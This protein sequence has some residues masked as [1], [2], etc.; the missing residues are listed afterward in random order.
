MGPRASLAL[1]W[2][3]PLWL[4]AGCVAGDD[5]TATPASD[6]GTA[7]GADMGAG[8]TLVDVMATDA[9]GAMTTAA[10]ARLTASIDAIGASGP[11]W[12]L[13]HTGD[14]MPTPV[15]VINPMGYA[16]QADVT[17]A[18]TWT[19]SV[20]F[21]AG[22][23]TTPRS[24]TLD[25]P[26]G[27]TVSYRFRVLPPETSGF[28]LYETTV[29][30]TGGMSGVTQ[31][32][33]LLPGTPVSGTLRLAG[34]PTAGE[35]RLIAGDG[36]D[37]VGL[38]DKNGLFKLAVKSDIVYTPLLIPLP[39]PGST[40]PPAGAPHLGAAQTGIKFVGAPFDIPGGVAVSGSVVDGAAAPIAQAHVVLRAGALPSSTGI[41]D[42]TGAWSLYAEAATYALSFDAPDW[43]Q[44][45][46]ANVVVPAAGTSLAIAY[47]T[48]RTAVGGSVTNDDGTAAAMA[49]VT[50]TSQP[51][52]NVATVSVGGG[53]AQPAAGRV[54]RIVMTRADGTLPPLQLPQGTYHVTVEPAGPSL[55]GLTAFNETVGS[56][57]ATWTLPLAKLAPL[58][59]RVVGLDGK[60]VAGVALTAI[61]TLGLGAAP[62]G[63]TDAMG[64]A[65]LFVGKGSPVQLVV[66]PPGST[67]LAGTRVAV[68]ADAGSVTVMLGRGLLVTGAVQSPTGDPQPNV[69]VEALCDG[70]G[71]TTPIATSIS[72][73]QG[74][75]RIYLPDPGNVLV[76]GGAVD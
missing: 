33:M 1:L 13:T 37:A 26:M 34:A 14:T 31:N 18:G 10:P 41:S 50:I 44:A 58:D 63:A 60:G 53:A 32:L 23:C 21:D 69:R 64:S 62:T 75:Y 11:H 40:T 25:N 55:D 8:C 17:R 46:L 28:P 51:L 9:Q 4:A 6:M 2:L 49:R 65:R 48:S 35:V 19:F 20:R 30:V 38:A 68:A 36:P 39:A 15:T 42:A 29:P 7:G 12:T 52:G 76:D 16:V 72:D 73:N 22:P 27:A 47:T 43:P 70:C 5:T 71:S 74:V 57:P 3:L 59:I 56:S 54:V 45:T 67:N 24:I 66:E 61:E